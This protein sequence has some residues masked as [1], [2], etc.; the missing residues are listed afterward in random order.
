[1]ADFWKTFLEYLD[2]Y[3]IMP[4]HIAEFI[5]VTP[6]VKDYVEGYSNASIARRTKFE[7]KYIEETLD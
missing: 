5:A 7:I 1:M 6:I 2:E 4:K 3:N